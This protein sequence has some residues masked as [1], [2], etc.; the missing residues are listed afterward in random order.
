MTQQITQSTAYTYTF[1]LISDDDNV[2]RLTGLS[3]G[4]TAKISKAGGA[5]ADMANDDAISEIGLGWYKITITAGETDTLGDLLIDID[6]ADSIPW[7]DRLQV[8]DPAPDVNVASID[9]AV[10]A[11]ANVKT[12][13][14][15][16]DGSNLLFDAT[17]LEQIAVYL[18][19][20]S[21]A[22]VEAS[23]KDTVG[24][25]T[26]PTFGFKSLAGAVARLVNNWETDDVA[27]TMTIYLTDGTTILAT[28]DIGLSATAKPITAATLQ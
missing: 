22:N 14:A 12:F 16:F 21:L 20:Y 5:F 10:T 9:S 6:H 18:A 13:D 23:A 27:E 8:V 26:M 28:L 17:A 2:S 11:N 24:G 7:S 19:R 15:T 3:S 1:M 25:V 4:F